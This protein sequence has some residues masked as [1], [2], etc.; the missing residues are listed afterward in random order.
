[1]AQSP[2]CVAAIQR[3]WAMFE[4]CA[5]L[6]AVALDKGGR[7]LETTTGYRN[8]GAAGSQPRLVLDSTRVVEWTWKGLG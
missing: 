4:P 3:F 7:R 6:R 1:M 5:L 2:G 8:A